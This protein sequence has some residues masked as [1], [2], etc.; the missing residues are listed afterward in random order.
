MSCE[1]T[2]NQRTTVWKRTTAPNLLSLSLSSHPLVI[3][4]S[5]IGCTLFGVGALNHLPDDGKRRTANLECR[6]Q[7]RVALG[8]ADHFDG[9]QMT[10]DSC[11]RTLDE[12]FGWIAVGCLLC[13]FLCSPLSIQNCQTGEPVRIRLL[14]D[15]SKRKSSETECVLLIQHCQFDASSSARRKRKCFSSSL[16]FSGG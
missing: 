7:R 15:L 8:A 16:H 9:L 14:A 3:Y 2:A 13:N 4:G 10:A 5:Q 12:G 6:I 1:S 11:H